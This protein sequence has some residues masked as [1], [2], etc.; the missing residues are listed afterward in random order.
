M[1]EFS[2]NA[3]RPD[4]CQARETAEPQPLDSLVRNQP[5]LLSDDL[6]DLREI[7]VPEIQVCSHSSHSDGDPGESAL[8]F[9]LLP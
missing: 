5:L 8:G 7:K 2:S 6:L 1:L 9:P 4:L 3:E